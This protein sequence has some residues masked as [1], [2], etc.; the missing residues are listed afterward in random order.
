MSTNPDRK[1]RPQVVL[2]NRAI[3]VNKENEILIIKREPDDSYMPNKWELPGGKLERGQDISNALE[4]EIRQETGLIIVPKERIV[5]WKSRIIKTG[6]YTGFPY[7][8][9]IGLAK[10]KS[11]RVK[12]SKEHSDFKWLKYTQVLKMNL[13]LESKQ[14]LI[15]LKSRLK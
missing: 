15:A 5:Y 2:V 4:A 3:L 9:L 13:V 10:I 1:T 14:A 12:I 7:V 8:V 6:K 11:G